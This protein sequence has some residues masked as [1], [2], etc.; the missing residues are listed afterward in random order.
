M[1]I[2]TQ[3]RTHSVLFMGAKPEMWRSCHQ[4]SQQSEGVHAGLAKWISSDSIIV[5]IL[6]F[7]TK[8]HPLNKRLR[9]NIFVPNYSL[10][11]GSMKGLHLSLKSVAAKDPAEPG[12]HNEFRN[13]SHNWKTESNTKISH[14]G[15]VQLCFDYELLMER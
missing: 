6:S 12:I 15:K 10:Q 3:I 11:L 13:S 8:I 7:W 1:R 2:S 14:L 5:L 9:Y 4:Y